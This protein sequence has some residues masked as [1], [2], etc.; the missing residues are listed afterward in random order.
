[1][2]AS[3]NL[4]ALLI[5]LE[6]A[7][8]ERDTA[9]AVLRQVEGLVQQAQLQARQRWV[10]VGTPVGPI[11]ALLPPGASVDDAARARM[12]PVPA[13]GQHTHA[14]LAELGWS[15]DDMARMRREGAI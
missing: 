1:M 15:D 4:S 9:L 12:D 7:E 11:A 5:V 3:Q 13:L 2:S 8:A 14:I 6:R 10:E